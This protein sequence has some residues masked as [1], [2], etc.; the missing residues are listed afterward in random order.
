LEL[1]ISSEP[2][3]IISYSISQVSARCKMIS[4][5]F[6]QRRKKCMKFAPSKSPHG[7]CSRNTLHKVSTAQWNTFLH[8]T[9]HTFIS[10]GAPAS[11]IRIQGAQ[12]AKK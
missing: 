8:P 4:F 5:D 6:E 2:V 12:K 9:T 10:K 1:E 7:F 3:G 11:K